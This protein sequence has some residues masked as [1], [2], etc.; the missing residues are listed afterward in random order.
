M[1]DSLNRKIPAHGVRPGSKD[2]T[3]IED[4]IRWLNDWE[5]NYKSG[6]I[7]SSEFLTKNTAE[8][9]RVTLH[10]A[11][12]LCVYVTEKYSFSYL[13]TGKINQDSLEEFFGTIRLAGGQNDH[14]ATPTFL[15]LYKLLSVYSLLKPPK[16]GNCSVTEDKAP[17]TLLTLEDIRTAY[18]DKHQEPRTIDH[19][20]TRL[21]G[22]IHETDWEIDEILE[23]D[24][25]F[26]EIK[27]CVIYYVTGYL[28]TPASIIEPRK[29]REALRNA[30]PLDTTTKKQA[31]V[32]DGIHISDATLTRTQTQRGQH[33]HQRRRPLQD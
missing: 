16:Y 28:S 13:L 30:P 26:A 4:S 22:L 11:L 33:P 19:L 8:G 17:I 29:Q 20:K 32:E 24:T 21:N 31:E 18:Q 6:K 15:Q 14:P 5:D 3:I 1:F 2:Y 27:N 12:D 10:S 23:I 25:S 9:L 7:D